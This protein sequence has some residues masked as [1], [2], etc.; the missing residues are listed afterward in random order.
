LA[1]QAVYVRCVR[2]FVGRLADEVR[3]LS[4]AYLPKSTLSQDVLPFVLGLSRL[5][6]LVYE[7]D[8]V[9]GEQVLLNL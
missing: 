6:R 4:V 3:S 2:A 1:V 7:E 5:D 9:T 8:E